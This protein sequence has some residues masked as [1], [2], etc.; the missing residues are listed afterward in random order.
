LITR[1]K[2]V[3]GPVDRSARLHRTSTWAGVKKGDAIDVT[4]TGL[5]SAKWE[6]IAHVTNVATGEV[7]VEVV[8][9]SQGDRKLRSFSP[10]RVCPPATGRGKRMPPLTDA[11]K[12]P[13]G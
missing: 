11:P 10:D 12:L 3:A 1:R 13:F 5:R 2:K 9:G 4:G 7:W 8:G 6:F